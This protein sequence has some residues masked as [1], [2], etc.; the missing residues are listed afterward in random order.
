VDDLT[1]N[2]VDWGGKGPALLFAHGYGHHARLWDPLVPHL[3]GSYRVLALDNRGHGDSD[4]DPGFRYHNAAIA[5]DLEAVVDA[6]GVDE[7]SLV[8]HSQ[9]GHACLRLAGRQ[10]QRVRRL[11]LVDAGPDIAPGSSGAPREVFRLLAPSFASVEAYEQ[12][13]AEV[14]PKLSADHRAALARSSLNA[15]DDGRYAPRL[16]ER[17]LRKQSKRDAETRVKFDREAWAEKENARIWHY[18]ERIACPTLVMRGEHS[19]LLSARVARQ[20]VEEALVMLDEPVA[21]RKALLAFL[22]PLDR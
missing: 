22:L 8:G 10:P 16:D 14:H 20:M 6:L 9:G 4:P 21:F 2:L 18:L 19:P 1:L 11:V 15:T 3:A 7:I 12:I 17:F 13:L 5:R